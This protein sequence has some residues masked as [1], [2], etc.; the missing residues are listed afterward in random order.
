MTWIPTAL[1][2]ALLS[3][4]LLLLVALL[5]RYPSPPVRIG[6][7]K[8]TGLIQ[9][10]VHYKFT[11]H[12]SGWIQLIRPSEQIL[13]L[14]QRPSTRDQVERW[15]TRQADQYLTVTV[16]QKWPMLSLLIGDKT[17][18]KVRV[19]LSSHLQE[20]WDASVNGL[21]EEY[22]SNEQLSAL[23]IEAISSKKVLD[24]MTAHIWSV[25]KKLLIRWSPFII[26]LGALLAILG[27]L[28]HQCFTSF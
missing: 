26:L 9:Y 4:F 8:W 13:S 16:P 28:I 11:G 2:G 22:L 5:L 3:G 19:A 21:C 25:I 23:L 10:W 15:L 12:L 20:N 18:E 14:L 24:A 17:Q 6:P 27:R 7:W 1:T